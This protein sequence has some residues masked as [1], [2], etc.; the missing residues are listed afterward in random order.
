[1]VDIDKRNILAWLKPKDINSHD[2]HTEKRNLREDESCEWMT[3]S[4]LWQQWLTGGS[5]A[6]A[7]CRRFLWIHGIPG[8]GKTILASFLIDQVGDYCKRKNFCYYYCSH[9]RNLDETRT[10]LHWMIWDLSR[11]FTP[12]LIPHELNTL[13]NDRDP[14]VKQLLDCFRIMSQAVACEFGTQR[15]YIIIDGIDES[16]QPRDQFLRVLTTIGTAQSFDH[17]CLL[18]VSRAEPDIEAAIRQSATWPPC[19]PPPNGTPSRSSQLPSLSPDTGNLR[20]PKHTHSIDTLS[21]DESGE[22]IGP[23]YHPGNTLS[24]PVGIWK[25]PRVESMAEYLAKCT[26]LSMDNCFVK[27][28]I[29]IYVRKRLNQIDVFRNWESRRFVDEIESILSQKARGM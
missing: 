8:A 15:V 20:Y 17:V 4:D 13:Y 22:I 29:R 3:K 7:T 16:K 27:E 10:F 26:I 6:P 5:E 21:I 28:A 2:I 19:H 11:R 23:V 24:S 14:S 25:G 9:E 12:A 1:V 18:L